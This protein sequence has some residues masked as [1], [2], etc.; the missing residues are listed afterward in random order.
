M[1]SLHITETYF[2]SPNKVITIVSYIEDVDT[3]VMLD[4]L[5]YLKSYN[6][7][8]L[9]MIKNPPEIIRVASGTKF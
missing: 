1:N 5:E 4:I 8:L 2:R 3:T 6:C 7:S 9:R